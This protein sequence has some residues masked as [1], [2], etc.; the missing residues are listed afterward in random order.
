M[1]VGEILHDGVRLPQDQAAVDER[2]H[3]SIRVDRAVGGTVLL[4]SSQIHVDQLD[5]R[6]AM[7]GGDDCFQPVRGKT[8]NIETHHF[9]H[10]L[11]CAT[12]FKELGTKSKVRTK[13]IPHMKPLDEMTDAEIQAF[14]DEKAR[15]G[16]LCPMV[17][18]DLIAGGKYKLS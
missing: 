2:R 13:V 4:T 12:R 16:Y 9:L 8:V 14:S 1:L 7:F 11:T 17:A 15:Q 3:P 6:A 5:G 18:F 10:C